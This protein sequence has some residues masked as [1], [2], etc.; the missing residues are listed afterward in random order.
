MVINE[1]R[2]ALEEGLELLQLITNLLSKGVTGVREFLKDIWQKIVDWFKLNL[3]IIQRDYLNVSNFSKSEIDWMASRKIGNL[4]GNL[5]KASQIRK[6]RGI[7]KAKGIVLIVEGDG[8]I[9][10]KLFKPVDDFK[11]IDN[12]FDVMRF[13]GF[14]GGFNAPT[15]QFF[16]SK[17]ATEIVVFHEMAHLKHFEEV[18]EMYLTLS[19]LKKES[20]VWK[21]IFNVK[22]NGQKPK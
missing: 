6:L 20:Y 21:Q 9:I 5:L 15:K 18:G 3:K 8:K 12:L 13:E 4:G 14:P 17:N 2:K 19:K 1:S 16:L 22:T 10:T 11:T 7:L